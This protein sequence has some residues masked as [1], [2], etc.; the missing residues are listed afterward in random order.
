[1]RRESVLLLIDMTRTAMDT[2]S[3]IRQ[4]AETL[5]DDGDVTELIAGSLEEAR[6]ELEMMKEDL[7]EY[8]ATKAE[9]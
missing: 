7:R 3:S 6:A 9:D 8:R 4:A 1:M 5:E 2:V